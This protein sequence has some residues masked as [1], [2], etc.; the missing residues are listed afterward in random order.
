M[1][2]FIRLT[3]RFEPIGVSVRVHGGIPRGKEF[4][5]GTGAKGLFVGW[6]FITGEMDQ[7]MRLSNR[8]EQISVSVRVH[9]RIPRGREFATGTGTKGLFVACNFSTDEM[10]KFMRARIVQL[11]NR[12]DQ[13]GVSVR[14]HGSRYR[15]RIPLPRN[16]AKSVGPRELRQLR[17]QGRAKTVGSIGARL[18][19][20][21]ECGA[22]VT[23]VEERSGE[24]R[25]IFADDGHG[26]SAG[27]LREVSNVS[28][29]TLGGPMMIRRV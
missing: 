21:T 1:D 28:K 12:F 20:T 4:A 8:F 26:H 17:M 27:I 16:G 3:K 7:F 25:G 19:G 15:R 6:T 23:C 24:S 9:G 10:D 5:A 13:I 22:G 14:V 18:G 11:T 29:G 2:K